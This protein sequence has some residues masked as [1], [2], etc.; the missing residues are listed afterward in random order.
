MNSKLLLT[1]AAAACCAAMTVGVP[2]ASAATEATSENWAGYEVTNGSSN[3]SAVSGGWV[4]PTAR[5]TSQNPTY[6][7]F[8]VGLGGGAPSSSA[9]E[10]IGTQSDCTGSETGRYFAWYELVPKAPVRLDMQISPGDRMYARVTVSGSTVRLSLD[11]HTTGAAVSKTLRMAN[12]DTSTAEWVAEAPSQCMSSLQN[13]TPLALADFGS[14][15]FTNAYATSAG[16]TGS[17]GAWNTQAISL[18]PSGA[19]IYAGGY[20]GYG[21]G[22][23]AS[24]S[25]NTAGAQPSSLSATGTDFSATYAAG[26]GSPAQDTSGQGS[27]YGYGG[28]GGYWGYGGYG[29]YGYGYGYGG[30][31][32]YD[33]GAFMP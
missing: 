4:Q 24:S 32:G 7:A 27:G 16:H 31:Y 30:A 1:S 8:W 5:C 18:A 19:S 3:F 13:C 17:I 26:G 28:Y 14:V 29:G 10:Q 2:A 6:S 9:L 22:S 33:P 23:P 25:S 20:G 11:D 21:L 12:P 15:K